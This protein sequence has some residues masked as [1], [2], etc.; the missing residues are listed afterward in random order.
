MMPRRLS[1]DAEASSSCATLP[2]PD[3]VAARSEQERRHAGALPA[4]L[5]EAHAGQALWQEF[6]DHGASLNN[7]LNEVLWIHGG[8]AWRVFQVC[9]SC[10]IR[11]FFPCRFRIRAFP[12]FVFFCTLSA[13]DK[14]RRAELGRGTTTSTS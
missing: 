14:S 7:T 13:G 11:S 2:A 12:D 3:A 6:R 9:V 5:D 4:H 10:W 8:P 1:H